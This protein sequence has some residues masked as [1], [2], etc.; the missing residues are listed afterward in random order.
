MT[1]NFYATFLIYNRIH[2]L[3]NFCQIFQQSHFH[4]MKCKTTV[5]AGAVKLKKNPL[6][7]RTSKKNLHGWQKNLLV[8]IKNKT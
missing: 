1:F 4:E 7:H 8:H 3:I 2:N 6:V 5:T